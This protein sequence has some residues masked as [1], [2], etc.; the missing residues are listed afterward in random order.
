MTKFTAI[1]P[2][3]KTHTRTSK[4]RIYT[5]TV[6]AL[7]SAPRAVLN[8]TSKEARAMHRQNFAYYRE[9]ADGTSRFLER[10]SWETEAQQAERKANGIENGIKA[11]DGCTNAQEFE[12][13]M[14]SRELA[15]IQKQREEGY[16]DTYHNMGWCGRLDLAQ[17]LKTTSENR[18]WIEVTI[19]KAC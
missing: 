1:D 14:V 9:M 16:Y 18:N 13:M 19:L 15:R 4:E 6:V 11:L 17:K 2:A 10:K 5:H 12:N 7:P 8:V 3:G